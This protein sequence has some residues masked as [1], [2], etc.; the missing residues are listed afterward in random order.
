MQS[1]QAHPWQTHRRSHRMRHSIRNVV[2]F[3]V[4]ED[5]VPE[6]RKPGNRSR[7]RG[8]EE[9]R[10]NF[11]HP[12]RSAQFPRQSSRRTKPVQV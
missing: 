2:E 3:Q 4:E 6:A 9:L 8:R 1:H 5:V 11:K 10:P 7:T 12:G